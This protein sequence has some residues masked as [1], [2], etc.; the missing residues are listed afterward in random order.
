MRVREAFRY[1]WPY[2][3]VDRDAKGRVYL[4][5]RASR[6]HI[7]RNDHRSIG[8][9]HPVSDGRH[10]LIASWVVVGKAAGTGI[11]EDRPCTSH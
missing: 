6:S 7:R 1:F 9:A 11:P 4:A 10:A 2:R 8:E 5:T 3:G